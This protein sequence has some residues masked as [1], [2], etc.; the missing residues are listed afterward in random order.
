[1]ARCAAAQPPRRPRGE[2]RRPAAAVHRACSWMTRA[3]QRTGAQLPAAVNHYATTDGRPASPPRT[4]AA[5]GWRAG[6]AP[7][8]RPVSCS[9]LLGSAPP[10]LPTAPYWTGLFWLCHPVVEVF[11]KVLNATIGYDAD[12]AW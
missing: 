10:E 2:G 4:R 12:S 6:Q 3:A 7:K 11:T 9:A 8:R 1:M 5:G